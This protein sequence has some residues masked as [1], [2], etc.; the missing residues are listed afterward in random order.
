MTVTC[1]LHI[2][3]NTQI[4]RQWHETYQSHLFSH[5]PRQLLIHSWQLS[6]GEQTSPFLNTPFPKIGR[7]EWMDEWVDG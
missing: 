2:P 3:C 6:H 7:N 5:F 4:Q 1:I